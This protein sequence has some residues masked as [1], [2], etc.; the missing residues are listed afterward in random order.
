[1]TGR[2]GRADGGA[3]MNWRRGSCVSLGPP[4]HRVP[5]PLTAPSHRINQRARGGRRQPGSRAWKRQS[6][7][8]CSCWESSCI[9]A[10]VTVEP[11]RR[12]HLQSEYGERGQPGSLRIM[13][14]DGTK[15]EASPSK[16]RPRPESRQAKGGGNSQ[17]TVAVVVAVA[18]VVMGVSE[19]SSSN[20]QRV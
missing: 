12:K 10:T 3:R 19:T 7:A 2:A 11:T 14:H 20:R 18:V 13:N 17:R 4:V 15:L 16:R 1:M 8:Y 6:V 9:N 5:G